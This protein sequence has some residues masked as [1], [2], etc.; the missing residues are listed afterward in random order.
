MTNI[1]KLLQDKDPNSKIKITL[2]INDEEVSV[3]EINSE[4]LT[5][6][7]GID[8]IEAMSSQVV[9]VY[10][11]HNGIIDIEGNLIPPSPNEPKDFFNK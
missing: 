9:A 8:M 10:Y 2:V 1:Y 11:Q 3:G 5:N 4:D 7:L 6:D